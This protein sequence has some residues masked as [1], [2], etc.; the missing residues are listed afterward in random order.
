MDAVD[1]AG[2]DEWIQE[3]ATSSS[4]NLHEARLVAAWET[5]Q[6]YATSDAAGSDTD[7]WD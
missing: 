1:E 7:G 2:M 3:H 6:D 4:P 5:H